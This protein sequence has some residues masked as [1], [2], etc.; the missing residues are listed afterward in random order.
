MFALLNGLETLLE[1]GQTQSSAGICTDKERPQLNLSQE[2]LRATSARR[3]H[4]R[5]DPAP[6]RRRSGAWRH[7]KYFLK[8]IDPSSGPS[9]RQE[10]LEHPQHTAGIAVPD[11]N[12]ARPV[13]T[14]SG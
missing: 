9:L 11:L 2:P 8:A 3:F 1:R 7:L 4:A 12:G 10:Q 14:T 5:E 13:L 6:M